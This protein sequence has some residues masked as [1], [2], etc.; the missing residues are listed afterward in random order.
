MVVV[1]LITSLKAGD[2]IPRPFE[3]AVLQTLCFQAEGVKRYGDIE[4]REQ[5]I[6]SGNVAALGPEAAF[7]CYVEI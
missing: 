5:D 2:S 6:A 1:H 7:G 3:A 4:R